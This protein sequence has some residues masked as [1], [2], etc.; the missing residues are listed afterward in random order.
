VVPGRPV[1][2]QSNAFA[3]IRYTLNHVRSSVFKRLAILR[4]LQKP[5]GARRYFDPE[6]SAE[7]L[8]AM[9]E[10]RRR[11]H[12]DTRGVDSAREQRTRKGYLH[13]HK[14]K[15]GRPV[16]GASRVLRRFVV[17]GYEFLNSTK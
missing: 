9:L 7:K 1:H 5:I 6:R 15:L 2:E 12:A 14:D 16:V 4:G 13:A 3:T 17:V 11:F 10:W 8:A